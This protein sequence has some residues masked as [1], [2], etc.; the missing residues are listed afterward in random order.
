MIDT[1]Q[2]IQEGQL[3]EFDLCIAGAG[4]AG[5]SMALQL[6]GSGLK[7]ALLEGGGL[8]PPPFSDQHPFHGRNVGREY[9]LIGTRLRYFGGTT[10]HWGGWCRPLDPI[11]FERR[12]HS[13][14]SGWPL[15]RQDL[16]PAYREACRLCEI[17][18]PLFD[19][20]DLGET[21]RPETEFFHHYDQD[22]AAKNFRFSPPTRF[23]QRYRPDIEKAADVTCF[24][25]STLVEIERN[26]KRVE[27]LRLRSQ[28][29][30]FFVKATTVVLALGG[31]ENARLLLA[32][33]SRD[34]QG[35]GNESGFVGRCFADHL[36]RTLGQVLTSWKAP[37]VM[38]RHDGL[39][40]LPHLS[41]SPQILRS[42]GLV[43]FGVAFLSSRG[44][45]FL[46][47]DYLHDQT[48]FADWKGSS[49]MGFYH[50]VARFEPTPNPDSRVTLIEERDQYGLRRVQLDWKLNEAEFE[51][52]DRISEILARRIGAAGVGR[53]RRAFLNPKGA[54]Q[55]SMTY[56]AHQ[57]GT[58]RMSEDPTRGVV[59]ANCRV[60][61]L[62]NLY[63]AG[64]S[65]F[66]TFGFANPTLTIVAL[67]VRLA[68]HLRDRLKPEK[69]DG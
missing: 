42:Q 61:S 21:G 28:E 20:Q 58:T 6:E 40:L 59:D 56:Q 7:I 25:D 23:G 67:A 19:L 60:H 18:P 1:P 27:R 10:N 65:V 34:P 53:M 22:L 41:L 16:D 33:D 63:L 4:A 11:D 62:E 43:N 17:D 24:I 14:L 47:S 54:R 66:P 2:S 5:I 37:Y 9:S 35:L 57:L 49:K 32:S 12:S 64:S 31:I 48:L 38:Y 44:E 68:E 26:G 51:S 8:N 30:E 55:A 3:L 29:K 39:Q 15:T 69:K 50:M 36:G 46:S 52:L 13:D 45:Q